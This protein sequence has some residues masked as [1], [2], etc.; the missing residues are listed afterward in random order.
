[1]KRLSLLGFVHSFGLPDPVLNTTLAIYMQCSDIKLPTARPLPDNFDDV[2]QI[3][4]QFIKEIIQIG[5]N[6]SH[7]F[8]SVE[9][10]CSSYLDQAQCHTLSIL[11]SDENQFVF[12]L[13]HD[14]VLLPSRISNKLS[15]LVS[16]LKH[17]EVEYIKFNRRSNVPIRSDR[18]CFKSWTV[19]NVPLLRTGGYSNYPHLIT[20]SF[21]RQLLTLDMCKG[22]TFGTG[23]RTSDFE[24]MLQRRCKPDEIL[25]DSCSNFIRREAEF[26]PTFLY[27]HRGSPQVALHVDGRRVDNFFQKYR[28]SGLASAVELYLNGSITDK[29]MLQEIDARLNG[30]S[31]VYRQK[32]HLYMLK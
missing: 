2:P 1:M 31:N 21:I 26:C 5:R 12:L 4:V 14:T 27:G 22:N 18:P 23:V 25:A 28:R 9:Y 6:Y 30:R 29:A 19:Q 17:T 3:M 10:Y 7:Y 32:K 13:E 24:A 8:D 11:S 20:S 16:V 15:E